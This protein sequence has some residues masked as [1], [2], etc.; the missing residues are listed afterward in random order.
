MA[1]DAARHSLADPPPI[2]FAPRGPADAA[3]AGARDLESAVALAT[4]QV[5][6]LTADVAAT[7]SE[8]V[9]S[10]NAAV[11]VAEARL[12]AAAARAVELIERAAARAE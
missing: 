1:H 9:A 7:V 5:A 4:H 3:L 10:L 12:E 6:A 8:A 2:T 11:E